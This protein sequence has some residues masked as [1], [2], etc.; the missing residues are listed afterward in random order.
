MTLLWDSEG[1]FLEGGWGDGHRLSISVMKE[2]AAEML[3]LLL[4]WYQ[5]VFLNNDGGS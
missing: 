2:T 1:F 3:E 5:Q 4:T